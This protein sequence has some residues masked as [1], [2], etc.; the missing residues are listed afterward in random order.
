VTTAAL[1]LAAHAGPQVWMP[2]QAVAPP[3]VTPTQT[4]MGPMQ[5]WTGPQWV[6]PPP[7]GGGQPTWQ[8]SIPPQWVGPPQV[9]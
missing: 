4:L 8:V 5:V 1:A 2:P 6:T 7:V 3:Q 9:G